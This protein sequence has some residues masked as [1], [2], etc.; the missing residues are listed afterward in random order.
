MVENGFSKRIF[1]KASPKNIVPL[2][3]F[4]GGIDTSPLMKRV[5]YQ[6]F[7][8]LFVQKWWNPE[9]FLCS[10]HTQG[11]IFIN[12]FKKPK[13]LTCNIC[14]FQCSAN[15]H[16]FQC[17]FL[18]ELGLPASSIVDLTHPMSHI[19]VTCVKAI[20]K[21]GWGLLKSI[22]HHNINTYS[23]LKSTWNY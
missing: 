16:L 22:S 11:Y 7:F 5:K 12:F 21:F 2:S 23:S 13:M 17:H 19:H 4:S 14:L 6:C 15:Y 8:C 18:S 1:E 20:H 3:T 9:M 10:T